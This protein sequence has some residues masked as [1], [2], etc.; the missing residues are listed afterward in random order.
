MGEGDVA[1]R[2][3]CNDKMETNGCSS[4]PNEKRRSSKRITIRLKTL[5]HVQSISVALATV[6]FVVKCLLC[7]AVVLSLLAPFMPFIAIFYILKTT[8]RVA[9]KMT[10]N[11]IRLTAMDALWQ[12]LTEENRLVINSVLCIENQDGV[13]E[14][15]K[16]FRQSIMERMVNATNDKGELLYPR[17]RCYII[18]GLFQY[19]FQEDQSFKIENHVFKWEGDVP[20]SKDELAAI[21]S[22][23]SNEPLPEGRSPWYFCCIPTNFGDKDLA[24]LFRIKHSIADGVSLVKL[25]NY[26]LSDKQV[27]QKWL[28]RSS[29]GKSFLLAKALLLAPLY[30]LK[31]ILALADRSILHGTN[32]SGV[33]KVAWH[34]AFELKLIKDIKTATGTTVND[35]LMSCLSLAL[36]RYFQKKGVENPDDFTASVP[37]DVRSAAS[38]AESS[39]ENKFSL[40]FPKLAVATDGAVKQLYE[41]KA[42]MDNTKESGEPFASAAII[43]LGQELLPEFLTSK[44]NRFLANK[45]SCVI[46][47]VPGPQQ[48]FT[49]KG[50][51]IKY[52]V[53]WPPQKDSIGV[54]L[55]IYSYAE[56]VII[57]VQGDVSVLSDP[58]L[59]VEEFGSA[60]KELAS[61]TLQ[62]DEPI[63]DAG[64][65]DPKNDANHQN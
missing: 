20:R 26:T 61:C 19:F 42:R 43:F 27:P 4:V 21:V 35:V 34:E 3:Q 12:Q 48:P 25:V 60:L 28:K 1:K 63:G 14:E 37:V 8:E 6:W 31:L 15:V 49:V 44:F 18:P 23:L 32:L 7:Y 5:V 52:T 13:E 36:R 29:N 46:S 24:I 53:F 59:I 11:R 22:K 16:V 56:Q 54:G 30:S 2:K 9:V 38:L 45:A 64:I 57:G 55:S 41:T 10:S 62:T 40:V 51:R 47:N 50:R 33:K 58:E 17:T 65:D 39:L